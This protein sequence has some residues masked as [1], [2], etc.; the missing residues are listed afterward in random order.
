VIGTRVLGVYTVT[1]AIGE[2]GMGAVWLATSNT[3]HRVV[4]KVLHPEYTRHPIVLQRFLDEAQTAAKISHP[5]LI[6]MLGSGVLDDG[7]AFLAMEWLDGKTLTDH[8]R[9]W[10]K[11]TAADALPILV[12]LCDGMQ[13]A[14]GQ[15]I[16]HR[17]LKPDN[18]FVCDEPRG[19]IKILDFGISKRLGRPEGNASP[20]T[21]SGA[22]MG[23]P[24]YMAPEQ[25]RSAADASSVSDIFAVG[26]IAF[27]LLAGFRPYRSDKPDGDALATY[28]ERCVRVALGAE[29]RPSL[30]AST[31]GREDIPANWVAIID[32]AIDVSPGAR[33]QTIRDFIEPLYRS[34]PGGEAIARQLAPGLFTAASPSDETRRAATGDETGPRLVG[35][36]R[37]AQ[38]HPTTFQ[39]ASGQ[40]ATSA[41]P[42]IGRAVPAIVG[43]VLLA[44]LAVVIALV[45]TRAGSNSPTETD[46]GATDHEAIDA[47]PATANT[48]P[49]DAAADQAP[50]AAG[51]GDAP[52]VIDAAPATALAAPTDAA[53][54]TA[55]E[56]E[57]A[58]ATIAP[59]DPVSPRTSDGHRVRV[60]KKVPR[61][62]RGG[63]DDI[64]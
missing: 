12:Q 51:S 23:T 59:V 60:K 10:G 53:S 37:H 26:V 15:A 4:I 47:A 16:V 38:L 63:P 2:G 14:H 9:S 61:G 32:R 40:V 13:A 1:K 24:W 27:E 22:V 55:N 35:T 33:P 20:L 43:A 49:T 21:A 3:G 41:P 64:D 19:L 44:G 56:N 45:V 6:K 25:A 52:P 18:V 28:T 62:K 50:A 29:P 11:L 46:R 31:P 39:G 54:A 34:I 57:P 48:T 58:R 30:A 17:D 42:R 8:A 5:N 7:N 36:A